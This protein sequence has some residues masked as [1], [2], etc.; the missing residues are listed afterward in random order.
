MNF[1]TGL[2]CDLD[3]QKTV[4]KVR[5]QRSGMVQTESQYK[6][7]YR[8]LLSYLNAQPGFTSDKVSLLHS[9]STLSI[10]INNIIK[11]N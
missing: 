8:A 11:I 7:V 4:M 3:V 5:S 9:W 1:T 6:F 2:D 10:R